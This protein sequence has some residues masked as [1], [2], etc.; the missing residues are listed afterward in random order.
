DVP[1]QEPT[2][3]ISLL[4]ILT[5][6][7]VTIIWSLVSPRG[8][9]LKALQNAE[10]FAYRYT[11]LPD[12]CTAEQRRRAAQRMDLWTKQAEAAAAGNLEELIAPKD[13]WS[14]TLRVAHETPLADANRQGIAALVSQKTVTTDGPVLSPATNGKTA[15]GHKT[16][17]EQQ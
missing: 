14:A 8:K 9:A 12:A 4:V 11:Q 17:T 13:R 5:I 3:G 6:L 2:T 16:D 7:V 10:K 15:N 1:V